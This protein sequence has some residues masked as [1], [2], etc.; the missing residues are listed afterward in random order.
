M[1]NIDKILGK[2]GKCQYYT[3]IDLWKG[4]HQI[5]IGPNSIQKTAFSTKSGHTE[6]V[7]MPFGLRNAPA[8]FQR[9]M[10]NILRPM[11][12]KHC[13]VYLDDIIVFSSSLDEHLNSLQL[14]FNK[15]SEANLKMQLNK[16]EFL[17]KRSQFSWSYCNSEWN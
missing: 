3:T 2:L 9:C 6:Y 12:Y 4:F 13:L 15:L 11:L 10:N 16:C 7:R 1:T 5:E 14:V 17:K 8:T